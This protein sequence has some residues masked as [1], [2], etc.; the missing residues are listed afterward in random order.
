[1]FVVD[2]AK[3]LQ[4]RSRGVGGGRWLKEAILLKIPII[5]SYQLKIKVYRWFR[6]L[7]LVISCKLKFFH[8]TSKFQSKVKITRY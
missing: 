2:A 4:Q 5:Y 1:M 7:D 8:T 3:E 6:G